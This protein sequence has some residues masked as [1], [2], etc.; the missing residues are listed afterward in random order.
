MQDSPIKLH[1]IENLAFFSGLGLTPHGVSTDEIGGAVEVLEK[2]QDSKRQG[3]AAEYGRWLDRIA[4]TEK[5]SPEETRKWNE[6]R[7][8]TSSQDEEE[9]RE[10]LEAI[11]T[12]EKVNAHIFDNRN[13]LGRLV[14]VGAFLESFSRSRD[15]EGPKR[16]QAP[17]SAMKIASTAL[18][19]RQKENDGG[20]KEALLPFYASITKSGVGAS[21]NLVKG[22]R[23]R[24]DRWVER[25][26]EWIADTE[27]TFRMKQDGPQ[28]PVSSKRVEE[29][30][31]V[32]ADVETDRRE[33]QAIDALVSSGALENWGAFRTFLRDTDNH[34]EILIRASEEDGILDWAEIL[35]RGRRGTWRSSP[36]LFVEMI[37][38]LRKTGPAHYLSQDDGQRTLGEW[39]NLVRSSLYAKEG[40]IPNPEDPALRV[41]GRRLGIDFIQQ[42]PSQPYKVQS[43]RVSEA[44][45]GAM[46]PEFDRK[47]CLFFVETGNRAQVAEWLPGYDV[48]TMIF[49]DLR[50]YL[51]FETRLAGM[52]PDGVGGGLPNP[53]DVY[54]ISTDAEGAPSFAVPFTV[55]N[56][57]NRGKSAFMDF[58]PIGSS[59]TE[60]YAFNERIE[61]KGTH[62]KMADLFDEIRSL[63]RTFPR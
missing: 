62:D 23:G 49:Q 31:P 37:A 15:V 3:K 51:E 29:V 53:E 56:G 6:V 2:W 17:A 42:L 48:A 1:G 60:I 21:L 44:A 46:L 5:L 36:M 20:I 18:Q 30:P 24:T 8:N 43:V 41:A 11:D 39:S 19:L 61:I 14:L 47:G 59:K 33:D 35:D 26:A 63:D 40:W 54:V 50:E 32:P 28:G 4:Q 10:L 57:A 27:Q 22:S 45:K 16:K 25:A 34:R 58:L 12:V 9:F 38:F 7:E 13:N 52:Y 55:R